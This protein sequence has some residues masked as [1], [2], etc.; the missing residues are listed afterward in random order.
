MDFYNETDDLCQI[1]LVFIVAHIIWLE[2]FEL[3]KNLVS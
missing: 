3:S 1:L 2:I